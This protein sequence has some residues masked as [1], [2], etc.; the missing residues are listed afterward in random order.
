MTR[1]KFV[2]IGAK[3]NFYQSS[4]F[5]P[6]SFALVTTVHENGETGI[7]PHALVYPFGITEPHSMLLIS[8]SNSGTAANIRRTG[9][10][11]LNYIE[12]D[13]T[14]LQ[15]VANQGYPG[16]PLADKQKANP[17][18]MIRSPSPDKAD[19]PDFPL[20]VQEACQ[21]I[22]CT[23]DDAFEIDQQFGHKLEVY[24][25]HFVLL[26]DNILIKDRYQEGIESGDVFPDMPIFYG[27]RA[28]GDF[29]FAE[30]REPFSIS[31]P[32]V[33][34]LEA[35][36]VFYL[37][38]RLDEHVRFSQ[39]A[40]G[41]LARVPKPFLQQVLKGIIAAAK[42]HDITEVD[43]VFMEQVNRERVGKPDSSVRH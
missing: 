35:Q 41:M 13:R 11:A 19:D 33:E 7:G 43:P 20:V 32:T 24:A 21:I 8:R 9:K 2:R 14:K 16:M 22:E 38:N 15:G 40:C 6:M 37:A 26:V 27:F 39:E 4:A 18:T 3:D 29:W 42:D 34:G 31:P 23:W 5:M 17:Y 1:D 36:T 25:A 30:H 10:C 12:F 28:Q